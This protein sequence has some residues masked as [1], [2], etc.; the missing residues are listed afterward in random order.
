MYIALCYLFAVFSRTKKDDAMLICWVQYKTR[1]PH[2]SATAP[3][4]FNMDSI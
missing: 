4:C 2:F 3:F 1:L